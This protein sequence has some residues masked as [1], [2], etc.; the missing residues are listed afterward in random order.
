MSTKKK[1]LDMKE[2]TLILLIPDTDQHDGLFN[3]SVFLFVCLLLKQNWVCA[4]FLLVLF[5]Q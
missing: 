1:K 3:V 2:I 5:V 4:Y